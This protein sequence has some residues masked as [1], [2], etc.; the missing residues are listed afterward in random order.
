MPRSNSGNEVLRVVASDERTP[1]L[2]E[3]ATGPTAEP[4][5]AGAGIHEDEDENA[6][7]PVVQIFLL[8]YASFIEPIA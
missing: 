7:L 4:V 2:P 1:L 8:C 3:P 5:E 6:P